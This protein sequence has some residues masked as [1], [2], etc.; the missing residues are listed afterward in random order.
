M[1]CLAPL[2]LTYACCS[3]DAVDGNEDGNGGGRTHDD[4][5][6]CGHEPHDGCGF[7]DAYCDGNVCEC[8]YRAASRCTMSALLAA[9][10]YAL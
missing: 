4:A 1:L 7:G 10:C 6:V 5:C 9:Y 3:D 8:E 2:L